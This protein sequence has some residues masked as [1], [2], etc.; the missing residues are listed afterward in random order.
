LKGILACLIFLTLV[1]VSTN[2]FIYVRR[3]FGGSPVDETPN[4]NL[5]GMKDEIVNIDSDRWISYKQLF[6]M[7]RIGLDPQEFPQFKLFTQAH[8]NE[9]MTQEKARI[10]ESGFDGYTSLVLPEG[11]S[12]IDVFK[13]FFKANSV[14]GIKVGGDTEIL[15]QTYNDLDL[16]VSANE[17]SLLFVR[18]AYSPYWKAKING[19][20]VPITRALYNFKAVVVPA[21]ISTVTFHFSPPWVGVSIAIAYF[22]I[23]AVGFWCLYLWRKTLAIQ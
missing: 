1:D 4:A 13:P 9:D 22:I 15:R 3:S 20:R 23:F 7:K 11:S 6:H 2:T 21:G 12:K 17:K 16:K 19:E 14:T 10:K 18:D 5:I 8:S